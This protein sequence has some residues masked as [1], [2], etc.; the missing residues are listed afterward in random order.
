[1]NCFSVHDL[2]KVQKLFALELLLSQSEVVDQSVGLPTYMASKVLLAVFLATLIAGV[3]LSKPD[4]T[5]RYRRET[6]QHL[7]QASVQGMYFSLHV[8]NKLINP[9]QIRQHCSCLCN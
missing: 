4:L 1:M 2:S 7:P 5:K 3:V 8:S 9:V 6:R